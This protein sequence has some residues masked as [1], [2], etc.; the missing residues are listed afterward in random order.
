MMRRGSW[1]GALTLAGAVDLDILHAMLGE[2]RYFNAIPPKS[3]DRNDFSDWG[4]RV[5]P[6]SD[7]DAV[8]TLAAGTAGAVAMAID[9][10]PTPPNQL[11]VA[12][13]G[14]HNPGLME[15][16]AGLLDCP[17]R[18]VEVLGLD[19]DMLEAQAFAYLAV[20]VHKG[21]PTSAPG[22]TGVAAPVGGGVL[23]E[24]GGIR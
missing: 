22:T 5:E 6:L 11:L 10:C 7:A 4:G 9:H 12:G 20:R 8:A 18:P 19:G 17:V 13:G 3:L 24:P 1:L 16:I 21:L 14:R 2:R 23:S 15:M